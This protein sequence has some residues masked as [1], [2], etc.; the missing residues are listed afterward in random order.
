MSNLKPNYFI[1]I[2]MSSNRVVVE[3]LVKIQNHVISKFDVLKDCIIEKNK[4]HIS[5][6]I[7]HIKKGQ[8]EL[9]KEAFQEGMEKIKQMENHQ[10]I[11]FDKLETFRKD[12]LYVSLKDE[13]VKY[14]TSIIECMRE[15]FVKRDIKIVGN[16]GKGGGDNAGNRNEGDKDMSG[17]GKY[18]LT[19]R[20]KNDI[21][22]QKKNNAKEIGKEK[23]IPHLTVM[24]NSYVTRFYV[25][26]R[27]QIF[28]S[29]Y[30]DFDLTKLQN[31]RFVPSKIQLLQMDQDP[32][33][34]YYKILSEHDV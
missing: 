4:F 29:Y 11:A 8:I 19:A 9:S 21:P 20:S 14:V 28:P 34:A 1:C 26:K 23:V 16:S 33:T 18:E 30:A 7:L 12:V 31:E 2:P 32:A 24:K 10:N 25:N 22:G 17:K 27:P 6:L 13:S 15:S 5:L 3:E